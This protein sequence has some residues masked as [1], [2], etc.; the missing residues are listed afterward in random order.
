MRENHTCI[1]QRQNQMSAHIATVI[2][3]WK[4]NAASPTGKERSH[5]WQQLNERGMSINLWRFRMHIILGATGNVGS[6][7]VQALLKRR[8]SA[9]VVTHNPSNATKLHQNGADIA[10]ADV[11]DVE[12][13][14]DI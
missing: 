3:Y 1:Q 5:E 6:A 9:I 7:V 8:E 12:A 13:L 10:V 2:D 14:R 4:V 11:H